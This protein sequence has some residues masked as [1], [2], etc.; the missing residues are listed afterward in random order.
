MTTR[1]IAELETEWR[2]AIEQE[3]EAKVERLTKEI[4]REHPLTTLAAEIRYHRGIITL[5]EGDGTGMERLARALGE[6]EQG[7]KATN[8]LGEEAEPWRTLLHAQFGVCMARRGN[9]EAAE[10]E[11]KTIL[12]FRPRNTAALGA[13]SVITQILEE[14]GKEREAKRYRTQRLS[15]ARA[16]VREHTEGPEHHFMQF[17]LAQE[18]LESE[19]AAEGQSLLDS[20]QQLD[21]ET[22]GEELYQDIQAFAEQL[23]A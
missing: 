16:L 2:D 1:P 9:P 4:L 17:L 14:A 5:M 6:F 7:I 8:R 11:L 23:D 3:V 12:A 20:L 13:A 15:Y 19:Y 10:A 18:L 21:L 22:L